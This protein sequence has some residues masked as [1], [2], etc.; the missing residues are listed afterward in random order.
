M[1][2]RLRFADAREAA[3]VAAFLGRLLRYDRAA[4]V[5]L[6]GAGG[7]L[8]IF[9][10]APA[11]DV[12]VVRTASAAAEG[13]GPLDVT[14]SA[15][16]LADAIDGATPAE[17]GGLDVPVPAA[18]TGPPWAGLLPPRTGWQPLTGLPEP[19][20]LRGAV[21]AGVKEFKA[22]VEALPEDK[23]T[24][25]ELDR[26]GADI[27][28]RRL[29]GTELPL[30]AAHAAQVFGL[31]RGPAHLVAAGNWLRLRTPYGSI[32]LRRTGGLPGLGVT[33]R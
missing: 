29:G 18:V 22:K 17:D 11:L 7:A 16:E 19:D 12:V 2:T 15:G 3:G 23:R 30:R 1:T 4:A 31:L 26:I 27:W 14:V 5:R 20:A 13:V 24:R 33:P 10:K 25:S 21:A 28:G 9:G 6:Q 32:A 8:A